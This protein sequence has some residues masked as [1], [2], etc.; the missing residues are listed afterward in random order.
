MRFKNI[1]RTTSFRLQFNVKNTVNFTKL[2][3]SDDIYEPYGVF[4]KILVRTAIRGQNTVL[5][6]YILI[7]TVNI[8]IYAI[9]LH[10]KNKY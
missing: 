3:F 9:V 2:V 10:L 6:E 4:A 1:K 8:D 7:N 5:K